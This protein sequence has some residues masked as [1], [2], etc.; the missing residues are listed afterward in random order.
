MRGSAMEELSD[1][2][3]AR[4][5]TGMKKCCSTAGVEAAELGKAGIGGGIPGDSGGERTVTPGMYAMGMTFE[6]LERTVEAI[7]WAAD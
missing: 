3:E 5:S 2:V 7:D 6:A 4:R 1:Q